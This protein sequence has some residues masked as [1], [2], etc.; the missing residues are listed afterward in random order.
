MLGVMLTL[1][2]PLKNIVV[3]KFDLYLYSSSYICVS[4][5]KLV[6]NNG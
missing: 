3:D 2:G 4:V 1:G 6:R 5:L